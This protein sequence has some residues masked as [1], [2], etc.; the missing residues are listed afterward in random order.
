[1]AAAHSPT[2]SSPASTHGLPLSPHRYAVR[3]SKGILRFLYP[4]PTA[5]HCAIKYCK[6]SGKNDGAW[7]GPHRHLD[8]WRHYEGRHRA[9]GPF[10]VD[11]RCRICKK[12]FESI[13]TVGRHQKHCSR[14]SSLSSTFHDTSSMAQSVHR[15]DSHLEPTE[16]PTLDKAVMEKLEGGIINL[17]LVY[18][19]RPCICPFPT[20]DWVTSTIRSHAMTSMFRHVETDHHINP[21]KMTKMWQCDK[22]PFRHNGANM[23]AH[24]KRLHSEPSAR[25]RTPTPT[26][27][28]AQTVDALDH[29]FTSSYSLTL[30]LSSSSPALAPLPPSLIE[31]DHCPVSPALSRPHGS[32][33]TSDLL[34]VTFRAG[35]RLGHRSP[36]SDLGGCRPRVVRVGGRP[37]TRTPTLRPGI[38]ATRTTQIDG[39][40]SRP[41]HSQRLSPPKALATPPVIVERPRPDIPSNHPES[42]V[43]NVVQPLSQSSPEP[44]RSGCLPSTTG[45]GTFMDD[46]NEPREEQGYLVPSIGPDEEVEGASQ[47]SPHGSRIDGGTN[48]MLVGDVLEPMEEQGRLAPSVDPDKGPHGSRGESGTNFT[49]MDDVH[50]LMVEQGH[51]APSG[52]PDGEGRGA[53]LLPAPVSRLRSGTNIMLIRGVHELGEEQDHLEHSEDPDGEGRG[54]SLSSSP[55]SRMGSG[56][57]ITLPGGVHEL[58]EEQGH[59]EHS[60]GP[61]GE[62]GGA[63]LLSSPGS[64]LGSGTNF[65]LY[66]DSV[67]S[68]RE[69]RG[70]NSTSANS[71][72]FA[73]SRNTFFALWTDSFMNCQ[74]LKDLDDVLARCCVDWLAKAKLTDRDT[75]Q[76]KS[77][78]SE[79]PTRVNVERRRQQSRQLQRAR[80]KKNRDADMARRIQSLFKVYPRRAVRQVLGETS[81]S[82]TGSIEDAEVYLKVTYQR[83]IPNRQQ[84]NRAKRL[85]DACQWSLP[86]D[87]QTNFLKAPP[88]REEIQRKLTKAV[89]SS[90]GAD[91]LEYRH[92]RSLDP[93]GQLLETVFATVFRLGIPSAWKRSRVAPIYKKGDTG[94]FS[95]FRPISLISTLY[96]LFSGV[97]SQ[98]LNVVASSLGWLS[99]EQKGFLPGV[100]GIQEH[101]QMLQTV[102]EVTEFERRP[103]SVAW[104]DLCNAFGS[105][106]HAVLKQMFE[107]LPIPAELRQLFID[108]Y[109]GNLLDFVIGGK[110][111]E[112]AP[113]TG[114]R[115]GDPLSSTVF[116]LAAEPL[117]RAAKSVSTGFSLFGHSV[118]VTAYADDLTVIADSAAALQETIAHVAKVAAALGLRFNP[119]KCAT[120]N[121]VSGKPVKVDMFI[122]GEPLKSLGQEDKEVYLGIPIGAKLRFRPANELLP[123]LDKLASS[124]LAP[125]QKLEVYRSH[126]LPSLSHELASGR[127]EKS[128]LATYDTECR[129]F[130]GHIA[131][132]P[133]TA[134]TEF[135][136]A[137]RSMGGLGTCRLSEDA[138]IWTLARASQ[139]LTSSDPLVRNVSREQLNDTIVRGL[140]ESVPHP[141]PTSEFLS[142]STDG[143][144]YR[145]RHANK[146]RTN[147][148]M[149]ARRAAK[150]LR[151]RIDFSGENSCRL[152]ADEVSVLP[153]KAVRGL[154]KVVRERNTKRFMDSK[155]QG[156]VATALALGPKSKDMARLISCRTEL[157]YEDWKYIHRARLDILP[158]RGYNWSE[159]QD[160]S[161]RHCGKMVENG[162]HV[163]NNCQSHLVKYT[164]RHDSILN[165]FHQLLLRK[166]YATRINR[167]LA[168]QQLRPDVQMQV[169]GTRL[170]VDVVVAYDTPENLDA[171]FNRKIEKYQSFGKI[172]PLVVGSLGSWPLSNDDIKSFLSISGQQWNAFRRK[173]RLLAIQD[174][175][176]II[177][178]HL[179]GNNNSPTVN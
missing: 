111:L 57:N 67:D 116:N 113:T 37:S 9:L 120:L 10:T 77:S 66:N 163:L 31:R 176:A 179:S 169:N 132:V 68:G 6:G 21:K 145:L 147:L 96:R 126:L 177:R 19:G 22:C 84:C 75:E 99:P 62:D 131:E 59:L 150:R 91:G 174:S 63:S 165:L 158:I 55:G 33:G 119:R 78:D 25:I 76:R 101:T 89:N 15:R 133:I 112:I 121:F 82:Y 35:E 61:V 130:L 49:F 87:D 17:I 38:L 148:W 140:R 114:V 157:R 153:L 60:G 16:E 50:E 105:I 45:A 155:H 138:D 95:N 72:Q 41:V 160:K 42:M 69:R 24:Y 136:Y 12:E 54:A 8:L 85:Y 124:L 5:V 115:Q 151:V 23:N 14:R 141:L 56:T 11:Y 102:I 106:P 26:T 123:K 152:L 2:S 64:R 125:W 74:S 175:M 20:C 81:L 92:L 110:S 83:S 129:K 52:D 109:S 90:P 159:C 30:S 104:L 127:V 93:T 34:P 154:R 100:H 27:R 39:S 170:M 53:N 43:S 40:G 28:P 3:P 65:T 7:L 94:D 172:L 137:D 1:M 58:G 135:Y 98:R 47:S 118:K 70:A 29:S 178:W 32:P 143:G 71:H 48:F 107:S 164:E 173:A 139:L 108:I 88:S 134:V 4:I 79:R 167:A 146:S 128:V 86:D 162:L 13:H 122:E 44:T 171:A 142:G 73:E 46:G 168:G 103:M 36:T 80:Q 97:L 117:L 144:L 51:L 166:G 149:L 156:R 18:P 161:C